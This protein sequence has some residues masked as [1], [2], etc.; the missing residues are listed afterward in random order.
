MQIY[1]AKKIRRWRKLPY[2][3]ALLDLRD[4]Y[5][6]SYQMFLLDLMNYSIL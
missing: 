2:N 1:P 3:S 5:Y 6:N 4:P